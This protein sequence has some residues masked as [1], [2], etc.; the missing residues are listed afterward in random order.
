MESRPQALSACVTALFTG[1]ALLTGCVGIPAGRETGEWRTEAK[2]T[3][4]R[5]IKAVQLSPIVRKSGD[6]L[7]VV[8]KADC[9]GQSVI[10]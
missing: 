8:V 4:Q 3:V 10:C 7:D 1:V 6:V 5:D 9:S 2:T